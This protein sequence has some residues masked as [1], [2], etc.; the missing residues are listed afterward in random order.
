MHPGKGLLWLLKRLNAIR[1]AALNQCWRTEARVRGVE[2]AAGVLFNG[3][4]HIVRASGSR[5]ALKESV[6]LNS[7]LRTNP[8]GCARPATL[9]T[10]RP[11]AEIVLERNV[12]ISATVICAAASVHIGEG[13]IIGADALVLDNDFHS[14]AG[15][16]SWGDA[17]ADNPRPIVIGRGVFI[18]TRAIVLKGVTLGDGVVVGAG[19]VVTRD[20][21]AGCVVVGNPARILPK[22]SQAASS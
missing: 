16:W 17:A 3:R 5:I 10:L 15:P 20:V 19:A 22:E 8:L 9:C 11:G 18:G 14:P 21:P 13:T 6:V 12:G 4:P 7:A 2:L 1:R